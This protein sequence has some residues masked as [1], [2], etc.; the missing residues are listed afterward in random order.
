MGAFCSVPIHT[1]TTYKLGGMGFSVTVAKALDKV[2]KNGSTL[3][4]D[5]TS[6]RAFVLSLQALQA[7][8]ALP[9]VCKAAFGVIADA[10]FHF[11]FYVLY[12]RHVIH[13]V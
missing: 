4:V 1:Q 13:G 2:V 11:W 3:R 10:L 6:K 8:Q 12:R 5:L 7:L 9:S